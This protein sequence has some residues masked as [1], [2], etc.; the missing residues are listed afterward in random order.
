MAKYRKYINLGILCLALSG[1]FFIGFCVSYAFF[2][3]DLLESS[4]LSILSLV[5]MIVSVVL[6]AILIQGGLF[7]VIFFSIKGKKLDK[8]NAQVVANDI[9][10]E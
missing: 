3:I 8:R 5:L 10:K 4:S 1:L 2:L 9:K 7:L 6:F